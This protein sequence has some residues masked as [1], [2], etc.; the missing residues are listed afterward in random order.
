MSKKSELEIES[1]RMKEMSLYLSAQ[2]KK[3]KVSED[4]GSIPT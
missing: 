3:P 2:P 1:A 4:A